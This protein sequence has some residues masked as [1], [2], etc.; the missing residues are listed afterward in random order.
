V[1]GDDVPDLVRSIEL[2]DM[3]AY[4]GATWDWHHLH[5]DLDYVRSIGL[6]AP[7]VDGQQLGALMAEHAQDAFGPSWRVAALDLRFRAMVFAGDTVRV[8]GTVE[9][10]GDST[11]VVTQQVAVGDRVCATGRTTLAAWS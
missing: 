2:P 6:P 4:A 1:A 7:V 8:S 10:P 11:V 3:V 5:Y 9:R